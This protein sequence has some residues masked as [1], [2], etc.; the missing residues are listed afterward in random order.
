VTRIRQWR[1]KLLDRGFEELVFDDAM[2]M[3]IDQLN[4]LGTDEALTVQQL[5]VNMRESCLSNMIVMFL[6]LLT[7]C[8]LQIRES[9]FWPFILVSLFPD[10][11]TFLRFQD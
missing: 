5:E 9:F 2:E 4:S 1:K 10:F 7:S 11:R 3:L 8:E 6:R